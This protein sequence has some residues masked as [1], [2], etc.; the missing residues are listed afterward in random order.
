MIT[1]GAN[2]ANIDYRAVLRSECLMDCP[3]T[4]RLLDVLVCMT[5]SRSVHLVFS[6]LTLRVVSGL[7][8]FHSSRTNPANN[9]ILD[10]IPS[11]V[12][13]LSVSYVKFVSIKSSG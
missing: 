13:A 1:S 10:A 5:S 2:T 3:K 7:S 11:L 6:L 4:G 9:A 12:V 8:S